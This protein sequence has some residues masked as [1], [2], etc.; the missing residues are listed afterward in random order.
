MILIGV[1]ILA[2]YAFENSVNN[3]LLVISGLLLVGGLAIHI[4][5]NKIID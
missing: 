5:L 3:T 4:I 1:V 2:I